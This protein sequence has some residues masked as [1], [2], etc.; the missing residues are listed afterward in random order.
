MRLFRRGIKLKVTV[1]TADPHPPRSLPPGVSPTY[2]IGNG[3]RSRSNR[4]IYYAI[5]AFFILGC[6]LV[7][8]MTIRAIF[9]GRS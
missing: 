3:P 1:S 7:V 9:W 2:S 4:A 8:G 5:G 6:S